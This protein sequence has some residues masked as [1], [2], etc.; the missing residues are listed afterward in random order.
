MSFKPPTRRGRRPS[1][2]T[3][4]GT[5]NTPGSPPRRV[6]DGPLRKDPPGDDVVPSSAQKATPGGG[7]GWGPGQ[8]QRT[9]PQ[10]HIRSSFASD[11]PIPP[12]PLGTPG[13]VFCVTCICWSRSFAQGGGGVRDWNV[14]P[15]AHYC[16]SAPAPARAGGLYMQRFP[17][18]EIRRVLS[19]ITADVGIAPCGEGLRI[20]KCYTSVARNV[21]W[22]LF[23]GNEGTGTFRLVAQK[24]WEMI[25]V[26]KESN[27]VSSPYCGTL[28]WQP[29]AGTQERMVCCINK[30]MC[31][32]SR[33]SRLVMKLDSAFLGIKA[34][35]P[36]RAHKGTYGTCMHFRLFIVLRPPMV[37]VV[38]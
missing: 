4:P 16:G 2:S 7:G 25:R 17:D 12:P 23:V 32:I 20:T 11:P 15:N 21:A 19:I 6:G 37:C 22:R 14:C 38:F 5:T 28:R 27:A 8:P 36:D 31:K 29:G 13:Q 18:R 3:A 33:I 35:G 34:K 10:T 24:N 9:D 30:A 26:K 1:L